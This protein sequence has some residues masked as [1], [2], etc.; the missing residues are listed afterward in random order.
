MLLI[1]V[2]LIQLRVKYNGSPILTQLSSV[3]DVDW[4]PAWRG[5][6]PIKVTN[7]YP[8]H[9]DPQYGESN[10]STNRLSFLLMEGEPVF[11]VIMVVVGFETRPTELPIA[12][13]VDMP[14]H[15]S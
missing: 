5:S 3:I 15:R 8:D 9:P 12:N 10:F 11:V 13:R 14:N 1:Q 6:N 7:M 4:T 2:E